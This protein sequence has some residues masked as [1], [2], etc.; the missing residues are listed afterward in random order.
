MAGVVNTQSPNDRSR[1]SATRAPDGSRSRRL[2]TRLFFDASFVDQHHGNVVANRVH[3]LA[4]NALEAVLVLLQLD[5]RFAQ[6]ADEN[7]QQILA[8][9]HDKVQSSRITAVSMHLLYHRVE[10]LE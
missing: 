2:S 1:M 9:G 7:L 4:L 6:R 3:S 8:N 5:R 10:R